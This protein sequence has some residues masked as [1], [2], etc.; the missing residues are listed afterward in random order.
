MKQLDGT[1]RA[2]C[3]RSTQ[4]GHRLQTRLAL[5]SGRVEPRLGGYVLAVPMRRVQDVEAEVLTRPG[6][7]R[8][9]ADNLQVKEV[10]LGEGERR[11]HYG[12]CC[13]PRVHAEESSSCHA[14]KPVSATTG[15]GVVA[16]ARAPDGHVV[17]LSLLDCLSSQIAQL[18]RTCLDQAD[19][20]RIILN[21]GFLVDP[22]RRHGAVHP[23]CHC[24]GP[25]RPM[26]T[27]SHSRVEANHCCLRGVQSLRI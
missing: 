2:T 16:P 13:H 10:W 12:L 22:V 5:V 26:P 4:A 27:A 20:T 8:P 11:K 18:T 21:A 24:S 15:S 7:Y 23:P 14:R 3:P 17:T 6:P 9:V 25:K 19:K 1:R